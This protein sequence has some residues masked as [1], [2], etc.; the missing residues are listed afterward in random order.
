MSE[1]SD[2]EKTFLVLVAILEA[3]KENNTAT[4]SIEALLPYLTEKDLIDRISWLS[5]SFKL[6][7]FEFIPEGQQPQ[8][9]NFTIDHERF[10][11]LFEKISED[12]Y[13]NRGIIFSEYF[14]KVIWKSTED[15]FDPTLRITF[16][17]ETGR[18]KLNSLEVAKL[19][20]DSENYRVFKYL[21]NNPNRT[22]S[23]SELVT[24]CGKLSK[25]L[26]NTVSSFKL[27]GDL[28]KVFFQ[29]SKDKIEFYNPIY[30]NRLS[31]LSLSPA[32]Y[33]EYIAE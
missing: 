31:R 30:K 24:S 28:R 5:G 11:E 16:N 25:T 26:S 9:V 33:S 19:R 21:Y 7:S 1:F 4:I 32:T 29:T 8:N 23:Y 3:L 2:V 14:K 22:I 17:D 20:W 27:N 12:A 10:T 6:F 15:G 13:S 18:I